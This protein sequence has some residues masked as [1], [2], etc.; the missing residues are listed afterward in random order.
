LLEARIGELGAFRAA[1][2]V[3]ALAVTALGSSS[4]HLCLQLE[5]LSHGLVQDAREY[6]PSARLP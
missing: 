5:S 4:C 1:L 2:Q 3:V 6:C